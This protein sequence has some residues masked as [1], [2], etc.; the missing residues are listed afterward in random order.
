MAV[1]NA[2]KT[3]HTDNKTNIPQTGKGGISLPAVPVLGQ[4]Q[5]AKSAPEPLAPVQEG[6]LENEP[7][8]T[9]PFQLKA[10]DT[11]MPDNLKSGVEQLSGFSMNDVKVHYNSPKP[12]QLNAFAYAQGTDIHVAPGQEKHLP[13]EAWH[14]AQQKQ[15]RVKPTLQ[16]KGSLP[17][18][19]DEALEREADEQGQKA[20]SVNEKSPVQAKLIDTAI[21]SPVS[22]FKLLS[23]TQKAKLP[24]LR[25][26][27]EGLVDQFHTRR[28]EIMHIVASPYSTDLEE[29]LNLEED[30]AEWLPEYDTFFRKLAMI[31]DRAE[32]SVA[33]FERLQRQLSLWDTKLK[34]SFLEQFN[35][36]RTVHRERQDADAE[37]VSEERDDLGQITA[38]DERYFQWYL[39]QSRPSQL[40]FRGDGREVTAESFRTLAFTDMP[41]GGSRDVSFFGVVQHTHSNTFKNGM[42]STSTSHDI[43]L[44]YAID[45]HNLGVVWEMRLNDY[46]H[47]ADLLRARNFKNRF[48]GQLEVL[49]PG[50]VPASTIVSATLY[51]KDKNVV[52]KRLA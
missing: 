45:T 12:A 16:M 28:E 11:G 14:V 33:S 25:V 43:G 46:I 17:V 48:A 42:V 39:K 34:F 18:N 13:H 38:A 27:A 30:V 35:K 41:P 24:A 23:E 22:Q 2:H 37:L 47:V 36:I 4:Q 19:D 49:V 50:P 7:L 6:I 40:V 29:G 5:T 10:N 44:G 8:E 31:P 51:D 52:S 21:S 32:G 20:F 15:G 1:T 9:Q 26:T 3:T